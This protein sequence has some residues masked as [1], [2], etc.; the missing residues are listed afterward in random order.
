VRLT[1]T[2]IEYYKLPAEQKTLA[3]R[4]DL[5]DIIKKTGGFYTKR[6]K[7][8][9]IGQTNFV[10]KLL[11][12]KQL[13]GQDSFVSDYL[14]YWSYEHIYL[15][16]LEEG[17]T[18]AALPKGYNIGFKENWGRFMQFRIFNGHGAPY[19]DYIHFPSQDSYFPI[20][21]IALTGIRNSSSL[22]AAFTEMIYFFEEDDR[23]LNELKKARDSINRCLADWLKMPN[24]FSQSENRRVDRSKKI[25]F[26]NS[27]KRILRLSQ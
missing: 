2:D 1:E 25:H 10:V 26:I 13:S 6:S 24:R 20:T 5:K 8:L 22:L 19:H 9:K 14:R 12:G 7:M 18:K 21:I 27:A 15:I 16:I 23:L 3:I 4:N 11:T 17:I